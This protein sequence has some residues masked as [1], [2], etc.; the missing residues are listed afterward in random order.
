M[1]RINGSEI[2][3]EGNLLTLVR[4]AVMA[5]HSV[6]EAANQNID[7]VGY[8]EVIQKILVDLAALKTMD[9][10]NNII[11]EKTELVF[12]KKANRLKKRKSDSP[13]FIYLDEKRRDQ[14]V[15]PHKGAGRKKKK[16]SVQ[17]FIM[18]PRADE[19]DFE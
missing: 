6:A 17:D 16:F 3:L 18:D 9:T 4:E 13:E 19:N 1:I 8:E 14:Y 5:I 7:E 11:D 12:L 2:K 15:K 10:T